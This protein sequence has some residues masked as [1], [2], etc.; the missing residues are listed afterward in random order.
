MQGL[1]RT[2]DQFFEKLDSQLLDAMGD[3]QAHV[4]SIFARVYFSTVADREFLQDDWDDLYG[5]VLSCWHYFRDFDGHDYKVR[6]FNPDF[7]QDGWHSEHTIVEA[8]CEDKP[9]VVDSI[10][11]EIIKR[12]ISVHGIHGSVVRL[13]R[14]G[15]KIDI[16][17]HYEQR[18]AVVHFEIDRQADLSELAELKT[19]ISRVLELVSM[20]VADFDPM[21]AKLIASET[22]LRNNAPPDMD[23]QEFCDLLSWLQSNNFTFLGYEEYRIVDSASDLELDPGCGLG[24]A[25]TG[26]ETIEDH[27]AM[28]ADVIGLYKIPLKSRVHRPSYLDC[29]TVKLLDSS[30]AESGLA[31]FLGLF[32]AEV[33]SQRPSDIPGVRL[34]VAEIFQRS[35]LD[36]DTHLGRELLRHIETFPR[37]ELFFIPAEQLYDTLVNILAIQERRQV[38]AFV[39]PNEGG[40]FVSCIVYVPRDLYNTKLRT[41]TQTLLLQTFDAT[42]IEF[43]TSFS[44]SI[45]ARTHYV[46]RVNPAREVRFDQDALEQRVRDLTESWEEGML[47]ALLNTNGEAEGSRRWQ[48]FKGAFSDAY[49]S[50]YSPHIAVLDIDQIRQVQANGSLAMALYRAVK[51]EQ[52]TLRFKMFLSDSPMVLSDVIPILENIVPVSLRCIGSAT[53]SRR[54]LN[55]SGRVWRKMTASIDWY[56]APT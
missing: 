55:M 34:K 22:L 10:R 46:L 5:C 45:L 33:F 15:Q 11:M 18:E 39:C 12:G 37:E 35:N 40:F 13:Q 27:I 14:D 20:A 54:H 36:Q 31:R 30:G 24:I 52:V 51:D 6:V 32:T 50:D 1:V 47:Q 41:E 29:I 49:K 23:V 2:R 53:F 25:S 42:D 44:E 3:D 7:E 8:V 26:G 16:S 43:T 17:R 38:R 21:R 28:P 19:E 48:Q 9:F 56:W 4:V